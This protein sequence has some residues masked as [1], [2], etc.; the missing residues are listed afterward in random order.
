M[1]LPLAEHEAAPALGERIDH[2]VAHDC[3]SLLVLDEETE[4]LVDRGLG[5]PGDRERRLAHLELELDLARR[6]FTACDLVADRTALHADDLL[7]PV[8]TVG[9]GGQAEEVTDRRPP[10]G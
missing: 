8:A 4:Q 2:V 1:L 3:A 9:S 10:D 5:G 6:P 7:Q